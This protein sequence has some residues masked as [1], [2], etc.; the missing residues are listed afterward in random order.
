MADIT[1]PVIEVDVLTFLGTPIEVEA[2]TF[3]GNP[4]EVDVLYVMPNPIEVML[5]VPG[6][7]AEVYFGYTDPDPSLGSEGAIYAKILN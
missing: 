5:C 4:I 7:P 2:L 3:I 1:I 6:P